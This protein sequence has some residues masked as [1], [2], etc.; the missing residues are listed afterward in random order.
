ME[1]SISEDII[2]TVAKEPLLKLAFAGAL[3]SMLSANLLS[4]FKGEETQPS[5]V[6]WIM[7]LIMFAAITKHPIFKRKRA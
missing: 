6:L 4:T 7:M 2:E 3:G 1:S 5:W